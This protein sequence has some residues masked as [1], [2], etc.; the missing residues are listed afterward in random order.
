MAGKTGTNANYR[1]AWFFG[2][3]AHN[4]TGVW[5][6]NDDNTS[7][8]SS[9]AYAVTGGRVPAPAWKRIMD[10][11]EF[12]LK[13][14][15]LPGVPLDSTY[16]PP[17]TVLNDPVLGNVAVAAAPAAL[18]PTAD[19]EAG[20]AATN[21]DQADGQSKD[22]LNSMIDLFQNTSTGDNPLAVSGSQPVHRRAVVIHRQATA[23]KQRSLLDFIFG[24]H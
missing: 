13:P 3:S 14:E 1:D 6:G 16:T 17:L 19:E 24:R 20:A 2:F 23:P 22:V 5:V 4:V 21:V 9:K 11:A 18:L 8:A 7:M 10:V 15:G 12:G